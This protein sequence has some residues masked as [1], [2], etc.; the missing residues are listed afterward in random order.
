MLGGCEGGVKKI[1]MSE[2]KKDYDDGNR[3]EEECDD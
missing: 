3:V 1:V 2:K